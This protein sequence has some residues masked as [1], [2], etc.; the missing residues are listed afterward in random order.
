MESADGVE[1]AP[2]YGSNKVNKNIAVRERTF[3]SK[4]VHQN[5]I[6]ALVKLSPNEFIT[7][8]EDS[9]LKV[10][11]TQLQ[12][13]VYTYE[14]IKPLKTANRTGETGKVN[15]TDKQ[16]LVVGMGDGDFVVYGVDKLNECK[17]EIWAHA[18][19][20]ISIVSL[21]GFLKNKYF[22]TRCSD[23]H[24]KIWSS[25]NKPE[26]IFAL[27]N[28]DG[29]EVALEHLQKKEEVVEVV[30]V[31]KKRK[32]GEGEEGEEDGEEE[33]EDEEAPAEEEP[34]AEDE[35][36]KKK[37]KKVLEP[38]I[39]PVLIGRPEP[40]ARDSMI[41][42]NWKGL[43]NPSSSII[44]VSNF[45]T[46]KVFIFNVDIKTRSR[47]IKKEISTNSRPTT[48]YQ[49]D[50]DHL[51]VGTESGR[52]EVHSLWTSET[53]T[54]RNTI[55]AHPGTIHGVTV[56]LPLVNP[57]E[58]ITNERDSDSKFIVTAAGDNKA[59]KIWKVVTN[60]NGDLSLQMHIT[61]ETSLDK[62]IHFIEQTD[63]AQFVCCDTTNVLKFY[64]FIDKAALKEK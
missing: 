22:A 48:L 43:I 19:P 3:K 13:V 35:D 12:S 1:M 25:T 40:S 38:P 56:I 39:A 5:A 27:W 52:L 32:R 34:P 33:G 53:H 45:S 61:I 2:Q 4:R 16:F 62:G 20:I 31:K 9:S 24:V 30:E 36:N 59:F 42:L 55:D 64:D 10:W 37:K 51:L 17:I 28:I 21:G 18:H 47:E 8:S 46:S 50:E 60:P 26:M 15:V 41:E 7:A 49:L 14:T 6:T 57:S 63:S 23:G 58:L 44:C 29:N 54:L 11:D